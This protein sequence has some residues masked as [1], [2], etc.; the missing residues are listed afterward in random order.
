MG[1]SVRKRGDA[2][3]RHGDPMSEQGT[4]TLRASR[5]ACVGTSVAEAQASGFEKINIINK[6]K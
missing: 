1:C 5:R 2:A 4:G 6:I 3:C